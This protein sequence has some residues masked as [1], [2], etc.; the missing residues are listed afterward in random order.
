MVLKGTS[1]N[2]AE[3]SRGPFGGFIIFLPILRKNIHLLWKMAQAFIFQDILYPLVQ[4]TF[5]RQSCYKKFSFFER[6]LT[7]LIIWRVMFIF[8]I[9]N[10]YIKWNSTNI[11]NVNMESND[12]W[13][14]PFHYTI[15]SIR[16][17]NLFGKLQNVIQT[18][19]LLVPDYILRHINVEIIKLIIEYVNLNKINI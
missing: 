5:I 4:D 10:I 8:V 1:N 2:L 19:N 15:F 12:P 9:L 11:Q 3:I 17:S 14:T 16:I 6:Q 18:G 13:N 7:I